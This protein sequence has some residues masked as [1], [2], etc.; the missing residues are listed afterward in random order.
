MWSSLGRNAVSQNSFLY[1]TLDEGW[2]Q[3]HLHRTQ[4]MEGKQRPLLSESSRGQEV[5]L[6]L[7]PMVT[8]LA[9]TSLAEGGSQTCTSSSSGAGASVSLSH[10]KITWCSITW[11]NSVLW[12]SMK[13]QLEQGETSLSS[14][15][16]VYLFLSWLPA[17]LSL[18][19]SAQQT[20]KRRSSLAHTVSPA[21]VT[22]HGV[23]LL[24]TCICSW[25]LSAF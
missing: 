24:M 4:R 3:D 2:P 7:M 12:W 6:Q 17:C 1:T 14:W 19:T 23:N 9:T 8:D 21:H 22:A 10:S 13:S 18:V 5:L 16:P 11:G 25:C 15:F 20:R